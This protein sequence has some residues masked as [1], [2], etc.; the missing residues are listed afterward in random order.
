MAQ[1][2]TVLVLALADS[3]DDKACESLLRM[4]CVGSLRRRE[5]PATMVRALNA[6]MAGELWFPRT[7]LSRVLKGFLVAQD[8]NRLTSREMEILALIGEDLN[9]QQVGGQT[10]HLPR[11]GAVAHQEPER[12]TGDP[13]Q[14]RTPGP[15]PPAGPAWQDDSSTAGSRK[16][17]TA[18]FGRR[19]AL[20]FFGLGLL[21]SSSSTTVPFFEIFL[22]KSTPKVAPF[23]LIEC[24]KPKFEGGGGNSPLLKRLVMP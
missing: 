9:N 21:L 17:S 14:A 5:A 12:E 7:M 6:V 15:R 1:F 2:S 24:Q 20:T 4:G 23:Y 16:K 11:D 19:I 10:L 13:D 22:I 18:S 8:P 3:I